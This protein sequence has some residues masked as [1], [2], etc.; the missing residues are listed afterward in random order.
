ME[1]VGNVCPIDGAD[2]VICGGPH[3]EIYTDLG[4][5]VG[6]V[7]FIPLGNRILPVPAA[8]EFTRISVRRRYGG[9]L[10]QSPDEAGNEDE[11][12]GGE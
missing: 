5:E 8:E 10:Q 7:G 9:L 11:K 1:E 3:E 2:P 6:K 12:R 4:W